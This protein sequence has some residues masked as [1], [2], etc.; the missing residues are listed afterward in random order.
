MKSALILSDIN[1]WEDSSGNRARLKALIT[2]LAPGVNLAVVNTGPAPK[3]IEERLQ[4]E[5]PAEFYVLN[6]KD[7]M[8]SNGYG[9]RLEKLMGCR[10]F[11]AV[12]IEYVHSSYFLNFLN[13]EPKIIL[14]VHDIISER[15]EEFKKF[16]YPDATI[17]ELSEAEE[18]EVLNVYDHVIAI[19]GPD[20][21]K[22]DGMLT[23]GKVIL[24]PH[25]HPATGHTIRNQVLNI[26]FVASAY[27]PNRDSINHFIRECWPA[28][29]AKFPKVRLTIYGTVCGAVEL[30]GHQNILLNGFAPGLA[31]IYEETDIVINPIRFG[32]GM[33]IKN[34]EAL[35]YGVP[36]VT[37]SHGARGLEPVTGKAFLAADAP[38]D[39]I[40]AL[41]SL[42]ENHQL[43]E[44]L[45]KAASEFIS[46][47]FTADKCFA[48]LMD[49]INNA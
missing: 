5:Y 42:I 30:A 20:K 7:F 46:E 24:C 34:I 17:Y 47:N 12:I 15:A 41:S 14:D 3:G 36:L 9:R 16:N 23:P 10:K 33:K 31:K 37:T 32:A 38:A 39:F 18:C 21:E 48:P 13:G 49:A 35:A 22:L 45:S 27:L 1:F 6:R 43:R 4:A 44:Q 8:S 19:C 2:Y 28:I 29:T 11:D 25:P 26:T 40:T